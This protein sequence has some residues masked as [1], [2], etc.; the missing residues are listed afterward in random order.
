MVH[1]LFSYLR[2]KKKERVNQETHLL[3]KFTEQTT[4][5]SALHM[6]HCHIFHSQPHLD[7]WSSLVT[8]ASS[9]WLLFSVRVL[10]QAYLVTLSQ[11][12]KMFNFWWLAPNSNVFN[13]PTTEWGSKVKKYLP[14]LQVEQLFL[15]EVLYHWIFFGGA[16]QHGLLWPSGQ[17]VAS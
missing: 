8:L 16:Q 2:Q 17:W 7:G 15:Y 4:P 6:W 5:T 3:L 9:G 12:D 1:T 13:F 14:H 10:D 11:L